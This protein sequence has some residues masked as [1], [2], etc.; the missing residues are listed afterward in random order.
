MIILTLSNLNRIA[1]FLRK[2]KMNE[3]AT[4]RYWVVCVQDKVSITVWCV[5]CVD[6]GCA[7]RCFL[8]EVQ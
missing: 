2:L 3:L 8:V 6:V 7:A 4:E 1:K 5:R